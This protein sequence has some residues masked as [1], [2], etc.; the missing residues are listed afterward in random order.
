MFGLFKKAAKKEPEKMIHPEMGELVDNG[1]W[2][3]KFECRLFG[4][5]SMIELCV[6]ANDDSKKDLSTEERSY[7]YYCS[8]IDRINVEIIEELR[9]AYELDVTF[10]IA[11]RFEPS[12]LILHMNGDCGLSFRDKTVPR[13]WSDAQIVVTILPKVECFGSEDDYC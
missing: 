3:G 2:L 7:R 10:D 8:N 11:S 13:G 12:A 5:S 4:K 9:D 1:F 6:Y